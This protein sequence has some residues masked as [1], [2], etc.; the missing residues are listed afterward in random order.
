[1]TVGEE[2]VEDEGKDEEEYCRRGF[3]ERG[4]GVHGVWGRGCFFREE[5]KTLVNTLSSRS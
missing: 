3:A 4:S 1:M 5:V 2:G